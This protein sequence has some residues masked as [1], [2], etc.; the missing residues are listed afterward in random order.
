MADTKQELSDVLSQEADR[1]TKVEEQVAKVQAKEQEGYDGFG[2]T[3]VKL[4]PTPNFSDA[5]SVGTMLPV[6]MASEIVTNLSKYAQEFDLIEFVKE[7]LNYNTRLQVVQRF[8]SEQIDALVMAIK[9][10]EENNAFILGDMA[11]IGKG[12]ICAGIMRYAYQQGLTPVLVTHRSYLFSDIYRDI[13]DIGEFGTKKKKV[14]NLSPFIMN[15]DL[16]ESS[17]RDLANRIIFTPLSARKTNQIC[18]SKKLPDDYNCVLLTYSQ[19]SQAAPVRREFLEAIAPKSIFVLDESHNSASADSNSKIMKA[20]IPIV[21][22]AS[23]VLFSSATF[24]KNPEVFGLYVI[25]T[26]LRTAVPSLS[27]ITDALKI[28]GENVSEYIASGLAKEGQMIRR[29]RSFGDCKKVTEYLGMTRDVLGGYMKQ[30]DYDQQAKFYNEAIGYF[31][32][33]RDF[34]EYDICKNAIYNAVI[35]RVLEL[36]LQPVPPGAYESAMSGDANEQRFFIDT[37]KN[38]WIVSYRPDS[39]ARYKATFRE[40]LFLALKA[41]FTADQVINCLNTPIDYQNVDGTKHSAPMKPLIAIR[42]T[43]EAL[44]RELDLKEGDYLKND[45]SEYLD[46]VYNKLFSG[47][48]ELRKVNQYVFEKQKDLVARGIITTTNRKNFLIKDQYRVLLSDFADGGQR[49]SDIQKRLQGYNSLLPLSAIDYLR[50]KIESTQRAS[51]YFSDFNKIT[52]RFGNARE[53]N[54]VMAEATGRESKL[55]YKPDV[56]KWQYINTPKISTKSKFLAFNNGSADVLLLNVT[57]STGGSAQSS[58]KEGV[59]TRPRNMFIMQF[60]LDINVE[61]QKRGRINRTGQV[62]SPTY[63]YLITKIPVELRTYLMFRKKLRKLD[64]NTSANQAASEDTADIPDSNGNKVEDIFNQYGFEVFIGDFINDPSNLAYKQVFDSTLKNANVGLKTNPTGEQNEVNIEQFN[65]YVRELELYPVN[66]QEGFFDQMNSKYA[67]FVNTKK[68]L[69]EYQLELEAKQYKA[70]IKQSVPVQLNSGTTIFSLPLSLT[71]FYT[72]ETRKPLK[73]DKVLEKSNELCTLPNGKTLKPK[74]FQEFLKRDFDQKFEDFLYQHMLDFENLYKPKKEDFTDEDDFKNETNSYLMRYASEERVQRESANFTLNFIRYFAPLTP[75]YYWGCYG[76]FVGYKILDRKT[77]FQY[78]PGNIEFVFCFLNKFP[79]LRLK[80]SN[81]QQAVRLMN[82]RDTTTQ[83]FGSPLGPEAIKIVEDWK[84]NLNRIIVRRFYT[85]NI[86]GGIMKA[87]QDKNVDKIVNWTLERFTNFDGSYSTAV[88]LQYEKDLPDDVVINENKTELAVSCGNTGFLKYVQ[89]IPI[90]LFNDIIPYWNIPNSKVISGSVNTTGER[91]VCIIRRR[92][93]IIE[94]QIMQPYKEEKDGSIVQ[95]DDPKT[96]RYSYLY[97]DLD[98]LKKYASQNT[99]KVSLPQKIKYGLLV[100][101]DVVNGKK[102]TKT[103][104]NE[105]KVYIKNFAFNLDDRKQKDLALQLF[106]DFSRK[107]DLSFDFRASDEEALIIKPR[108]LDEQIGELITS[109]SG[110]KDKKEVAFQPGEYEYIFTRPVTDK[111]IN[112]IPNLVSPTDTGVFG[113]VILS[114]PMMPNLLPSY[115]LIPHKIPSDV[116]ARITLSQLS[117][118]DKGIFLAE[119]DKHSEDSPLDM[120]IFVQDYLQ[121]K[122][123]AIDY[124]FGKL[125]TVDYGQIFKNYAQKKDVESLVFE[126]IDERKRPLKSKVTF[127]DAENF[128]INMIV[129]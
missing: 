47:M 121:G 104:Y 9:S 3:K 100:Y 107:Y 13:V 67:D 110:K 48:F 63:T 68:A 57:A 116:L 17:I 43:G 99:K 84:P 53:T 12:R 33:L 73:K 11:G 20:A 119:L 98:L 71:D 82:I 16:E 52:P 106:D 4:I 50:E 112:S 81:P 109:K 6:N 93:N 22:N 72:L 8:S 61:V 51:I 26:A 18:A 10:F 108:P 77:K 91:G 2:D 39:I 114:L 78:T 75:V 45:F 128:I 95:I 58:P 113:G 103:R 123:V 49:I 32:E 1:I 14:G 118:V 37:Y 40:N 35:R 38:H 79:I 124:F 115:N 101:D 62:N 31:K 102:V 64:A 15:T 126:T 21:T 120:G 36:G 74:E 42:N 83:V 46:A 90:S 92:P 41:K 54:Y 122:T 65:K 60:E 85:G 19:M 28:G 125:R 30:S 27:A 105:Y 111:V 29:E 34:S 87:N 56:G 70:Y 96:P 44:F 76:Y 23:A 88:E 80:L 89:E 127:E 66:F 94:V 129:S 117:D 59:D 7:K 69:N 24:A 97:H 25:R 5:A 55:V 86:L